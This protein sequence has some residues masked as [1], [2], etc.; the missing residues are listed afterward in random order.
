MN[1]INELMFYK[2]I[3]NRHDQADSLFN[4]LDKYFKFCYIECI[5]VGASH[6]IED[7]CFGIYLAKIAETNSGLFTSVDIS[8][9]V[10]RNSVSL[11]DK[12]LPNFKIPHY[13]KD[14][15]E[16]LKEY[17]G[18][19]NLVH[20]DSYDLDLTN[21]VKSMLHCWLEFEAVR[22]KMPSGSIIVID[23][24]FLNGT[25]VN[26]NEIVNGEYT[27]EYKKID[28]T[29]DIVGKGSLIYHWC[30]MYNTDWNIIGDHYFPGSNIKLIIQK[31]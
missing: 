13:I 24:N 17:S 15:I 27:G 22:D 6:D 25:W 4:V 11:Y 20:L 5:E 9:D 28:I 29:Y 30:N 23:D 8:D 21:P 18:C 31:N 14:S 16:F 19:P 26:W 2:S 7:G 3:G 12:Y 10:I 1:T